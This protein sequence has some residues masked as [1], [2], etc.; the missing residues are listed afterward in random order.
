MRVRHHLAG[1][2]VL[3]VVLA[4]THAQTNQALDSFNR[5]LRDYDEGDYRGAVKDFTE[6]IAGARL[7][8]G[9]ER[10]T[11]TLNLTSEEP[12]VT[13]IDP[14]VAR[15]YANRA[16]ARFRL[17]DISGAL[18][19]SDR[20]LTLNSGLADAY[21]NRGNIRWAIG[22]LA[23]A[24]SDFVQVLKLTP[25]DVLT[26]NNLSSVKLD[27][28]DF[29][30]AISDLD[31]AILLAP[32]F[33]QSFVGRGQAR[34]KLGEFELALADFEKARQLNPKLAGAYLGKGM[35]QIVTGKYDDA[36][37]NLTLAI[38]L[39]CSAEL[40]EED[41]SS[42]SRERCSAGWKNGLRPVHLGVAYANRGIAFRNLGRMEQADKD[43]ASALKLNPESK[44]P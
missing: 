16:V 29:K 10:A 42:R 38:E 34:R 9:N 28:G 3:I 23:A 18:A 17:G 21:R 43:F 40:R 39:S 6:V 8:P 25:N 20:A 41:S 7:E 5:G 37:N 33:A 14:L 2:I 27:L 31:R 19:D 36:I 24:K 22:E 30:G 32:K 12:S 4:T 44:I 1:A 15:A 35:T 13:F 26:L 11:L